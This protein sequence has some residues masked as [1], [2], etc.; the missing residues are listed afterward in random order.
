MTSLSKENRIDILIVIIETGAATHYFS[1]FTLLFLLLTFL[2][3][4]RPSFGLTSGRLDSDFTP[5]QGVDAS[6]AATESES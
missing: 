6:K 5:Q 3:S 2:L 1:F 4:Y